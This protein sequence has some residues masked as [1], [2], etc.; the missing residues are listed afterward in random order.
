MS[1][2]RRKMMKGMKL[3]RRRRKKEVK[4]KKKE[5]KWKKI[6]RK[7]C[8]I[9]IWIKKPLDGNVIIAMNYSWFDNKTNIS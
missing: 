2:N 4:R 5:K 6:P 3:K 1:F 7:L 9:Y 8:L